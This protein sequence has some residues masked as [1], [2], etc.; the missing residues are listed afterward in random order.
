MTLVLLSQSQIY[1]EITLLAHCLATTVTD[2]DPT[3]TSWQTDADESDGMGFVALPRGIQVYYLK[4]PAD[5]G[6]GFRLNKSD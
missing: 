4:R 2:R 3:N 5:F 1:R 6:R